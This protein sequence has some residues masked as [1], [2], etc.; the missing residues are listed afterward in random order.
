MKQDKYLVIIGG[1]TAIGKTSTA[2]SIAKKLR[3]EIIS[4]DSRQFYR[5]MSIGTAKPRPEELAQAKHHFIDS[6]SIEDEYSV[7]DF[8]SEVLSLLDSLFEKQ[9][10]CILTGGSGLYLNAVCNGL[11]KFP[12]VDPSYRQELNKE[13]EMHGLSP[14]VQEL[15]VKDSAYYASVD[16]SN[17]QR[18]IRALEVIRSS[19]QAFSSFLRQSPVKRPFHILP[20]RMT[21]DRS[22]LYDRI[23]QRV[24]IMVQQGL[25]Q[26]A[27]NLLP[28]KHY[29]L[30]R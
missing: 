11:D 23:N 29:N 4:A 14:L 8:E 24:D 21:L 15:K 18:I 19:N 1:P 2:I 7:G 17:P 28:H 13:F 16:L 22:V 6:L 10:Y 3:C 5:E 20:F 27:Q 12:Y 25:K 26:E 9:N 30:L